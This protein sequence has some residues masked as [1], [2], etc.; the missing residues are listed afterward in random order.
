TDGLQGHNHCFS[1]GCLHFHPQLCFQLKLLRVGGPALRLRVH[2][3]AAA[4]AH[5]P[6]LPLQRQVLQRRAP[7]GR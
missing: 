3:G 5:R 2:R 1:Y 7:P 4:G 6:G